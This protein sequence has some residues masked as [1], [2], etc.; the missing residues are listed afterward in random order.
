MAKR[1]L[2]KGLK[3]EARKLVYDRLTGA[4]ADLRMGIKEK[5]FEAALQKASRLLATDIAKAKRAELA[6]KE[7]NG[8]EKGLQLAS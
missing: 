3:K 6:K 1:D 8:D 5:K 4:L 7:E 2:K